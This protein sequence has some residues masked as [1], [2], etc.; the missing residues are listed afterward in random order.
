MTVKLQ[1]RL[2]AGLVRDKLKIPGSGI[3]AIGLREREKVHP[4]W[5]PRNGA[6]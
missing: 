5:S 4:L 1:L 6:V 2:V 3:R